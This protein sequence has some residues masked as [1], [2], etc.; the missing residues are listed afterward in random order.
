MYERRNAFFCIITQFIKELKHLSF[1][2]STHIGTN[3]F[4]YDGWRE[5]FPRHHE[6]GILLC[7]PVEATYDKEALSIG[8]RPVLLIYTCTYMAP[9][10]KYMYLAVSNLQHSEKREHGSITHGNNIMSI[11]G[12][13]KRLLLPWSW[14][15][16]C[17]SSSIPRTH[18]RWY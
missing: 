7:L 11:L 4:S 10:Q 17:T 1:F 15:Y 6:V 13:R 3:K 12:S 2:F 8:Y 9:S 18:F 16:T 14:T 5:D